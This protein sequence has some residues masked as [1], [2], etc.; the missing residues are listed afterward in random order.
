MG[1][2][3]RRFLQIS[4]FPFNYFL[5]IFSYRRMTSLKNHF[6]LY[7]LR[8]SS[9][10]RP[11]PPPRPGPPAGGGCQLGVAVTVGC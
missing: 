11:G 7:V 6:H 4:F 1:D 8:F 10:S 9:S 5:L 3:W 2:E